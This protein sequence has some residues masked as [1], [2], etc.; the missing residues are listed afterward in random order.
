MKRYRHIFISATAVAMAAAMLFSAGVLSACGGEEEALQSSLIGTFG[1]SGSEDAWLSAEESTVPQDGQTEYVWLDATDVYPV[2]TVA[3]T[4]VRYEYDRTLVLRRDFTYEYTLEIRVRNIT[5]TGNNDL[6]SFAAETYGTFEYTDNGDLTYTVTLSDPVSGTEEV[7]APSV[8]DENNVFSWRLPSTPSYAVDLAAELASD[9]EYAFDRY[10]AGGTVTVERDLDTNE[11]ILRGDAFYSDFM[12]TVAPYS[13]YTGGTGGETP[14]EPDDPD[15]PGEPDDPDPEQPAEELVSDLPFIGVD[16]VEIAVRAGASPEILIR[17]DAPVTGDGIT[18]EEEGEGLTIYK[19]TADY[20]AIDSDINITAADEEI[21]VNAESYLHAVAALGEDLKAVAEASLAASILAY[22]GACGAAVEL[23]EG[24]R[25]L[26]YSSEQQNCYHAS[27][28]ELRGVRRSGSAVQG[29]AWVTEE[30]QP[31]D[32]YA[33]LAFG[34]N[35][36]A[37]TFSFTLPAGEYG[38]LSVRAALGGETRVLEAELAASEN[39]TETYSFTYEGIAPLDFDKTLTVGV[40]D[41][42]NLLSGTADYSVTRAVARNDVLQVYGEKQDVNTLYSLG[43]A[44]MWVACFDEAGYTY[45]PDYGHAASYS[46][47]I[48]EYTYNDAR[49]SVGEAGSYDVWGVSLYVGG[50]ITSDRA[51]NPA[52]EG[53][54]V[55]RGENS[56]FIVM[57]EEGCSIDGIA[58]FDANSPADVT[59]VVGGDAELTEVFSRSFMTGMPADVSIG[60]RGNLTIEAAEGAEGATLVMAGGIYAAGD[61]SVSGVDIV[62]D[63]SVNSSAL[64]ANAVQIAPDASVSMQYGGLAANTSSAVV[65]NGDVSVSGALSVNGWANGIWLGRE[66]GRQTVTTEEGSTVSLGVTGKGIT[67]SAPVTVQDDVQT[68]APNRLLDFKG[69][70]ITISSAGTGI[71][72]CNVTVDAAE[73]DITVSGEG[74]GIADSTGRDLTFSTVSGDPGIGSVS[75]KVTYFDQW[76]DRYFAMRAKTIAV[77]GGNLYFSSMCRG[78]VL[79]TV[80]GSDF[81][82]DNCDLVVEGGQ[83]IG[84]SDGTNPA[85]INAQSGNEHITLTNAAV[86]VFKNFVIGIAGW[87]AF[88]GE[89]RVTLTVEGLLINDGYVTTIDSWDNTVNIVGGDHIRYTDPITRT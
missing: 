82:F 46:A 5:Q 22:A 26:V 64:T 9:P 79:Y 88:A 37:I 84:V 13:Q 42:A 47:S 31:N 89:E 57:L 87:S 7:Y 50:T 6:A 58:S 34:G 54:T 43:K 73:L 16:G 75:V 17:S 8:A 51:T 62:I 33:P 19:L 38:D 30:G 15:T 45:S 67:G 2:S 69:G 72:F 11:R 80:S 61:F 36:A 25:S 70:K 29:F 4:G 56:A 66:D 27:N 86:A 81:T 32:V 71:E 52:P 28:W 1:G 60:V 53:F 24:E 20:A 39:D 21:T 85:A 40:Y 18:V 41:G 3:G 12:Q 83:D 10:T 23:T 76:N 65:A 77:D 63:G 14:E 78:G 48:G 74:W 49:M 35:G 44:A 55:T 59:I 68:A